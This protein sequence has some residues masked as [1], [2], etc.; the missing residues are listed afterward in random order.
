MTYVCSELRAYGHII[1]AHGSHSSRARPNQ[2]VVSSVHNNRWTIHACI[3]SNPHGWAAV[4]P[5]IT[6]NSHLTQ[7]SVEQC[8][9]SN[10]RV[11]PRREAINRGSV[12]MQTDFFGATRGLWITLAAWSV[13]SLIANV[14]R[15]TQGR[16]PPYLTSA[17]IAPT[18]TVR[19]EQI[20]LQLSCNR[21]D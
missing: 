21:S 9:Y 4:G 5:Q 8:P 18:A 2:T 3:S 12:M 15:A 14:Y 10:L 11:P 20:K 17:P 1:V 13:E 7:G 6:T 19:P 16:S